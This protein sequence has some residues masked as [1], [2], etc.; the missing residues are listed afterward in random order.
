M[1]QFNII[2]KSFECGSRCI[3]AQLTAVAAATTKGSPAATAMPTAA[4]PQPI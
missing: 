2:I 1:T 3:I 4:A